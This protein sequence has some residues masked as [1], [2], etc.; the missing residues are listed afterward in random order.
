M[1]VIGANTSCT[2]AATLSALLLNLRHNL[3]LLGLTTPNKIKRKSRWC[4]CSGLPLLGPALQ[5]QWFCLFCPPNLAV[6]GR[7]GKR[8]VS[9]LCQRNKWHST[10]A[11]LFSRSCPFFQWAAGMSDTCDTPQ[12]KARSAPHRQ[13]SER[14]CAHDLIQNLTQSLQNVCKQSLIVVASLKYFPAHSA[15][16]SG[17]QRSQGMYRC[18]T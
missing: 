13:Q 7:H 16:S 15:I 12:R 1:P 8:S 6:S 9:Q 3:L 2:L 11:C 18:T 5:K 10:E 4:V 17:V 14:S